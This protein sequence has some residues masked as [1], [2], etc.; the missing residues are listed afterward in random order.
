[1][2]IDLELQN[3]GEWFYFFGSHIDQNSGEVIYDEPVKDA[4]VK[5]RSMASFIEDRVISRKKQ[6]EHVL[7]PK[8]RQMER[9]E[10]YPAP[11]PEEFKQEQ[12]ATWDWVIQDFEGFKD[13][14]TGKEIECNLA[15][16]K[17]M[18]QLP[19]FD[20]FVARCLILLGE[21]GAQKGETEVKNSLT[22]SNLPTSNHDPE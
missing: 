11:S 2:L 16:K 20:R 9:I 5:I 15:N 21:A 22:G 6:V 18:M 8:T 19:V 1:M 7:N 10:Y 4:R 3:E 14:R 17:K 12:E 13:K